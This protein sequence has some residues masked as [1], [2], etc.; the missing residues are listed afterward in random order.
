MAEGRP[1]RKDYLALINECP[2]ALKIAQRD[3]LLNHKRQIEA[4]VARVPM[5]TGVYGTTPFCTFNYG[6]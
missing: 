2:M 5:I 4:A 1:P 3:N 6:A